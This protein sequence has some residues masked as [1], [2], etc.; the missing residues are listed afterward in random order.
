MKKIKIDFAQISDLEDL[1]TFMS[2]TFGFTVY[3]R[4][5]SALIDC[6][7]YLRYPEDNF[8]KMSIKDDEKLILEISNYTDSKEDLLEYIVIAS[9]AVNTKHSYKG[10]LPSILLEITKV[11]PEKYV[12]KK[13]SF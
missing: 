12:P 3:G 13:G 10:K 8:I 5:L 4:N 1:H 2:E 7:F 9:Y 6:L 11:I